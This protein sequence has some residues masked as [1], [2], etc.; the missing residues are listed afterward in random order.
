MSARAISQREARRLKKRV[1]VLES[2]EQMRRH[3]WA[4]AWPGG[5]EI[6]RADMTH[7]PIVTA[8]IQTART[9]GHGVVVLVDGGQL[10]F[11]ALQVAP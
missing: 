5:T 10:R 7:A 8:S 9:L 1:A 6:V 3:A 4:S 2:D 11:I